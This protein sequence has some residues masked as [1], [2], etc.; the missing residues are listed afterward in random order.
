MR[1]APSICSGAKRAKNET[2]AQKFHRLW[3]LF[4]DIESQRAATVY[5]VHSVQAQYPRPILRHRVFVFTFPIS[6]SLYTHSVCVC[7]PHIRHRQH[8]RVCY[9]LILCR[10]KMWNAAGLFVSRSY[11]TQIKSTVDQ[12]YLIS[13]TIFRW[14]IRP[15]TDSRHFTLL[16]RYL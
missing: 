1:S 7:V 13:F 14:L 16:F 6:L 12:V 11:E 15:S 2:Q 8:W 5:R 9:I 3:C 4:C 10:K